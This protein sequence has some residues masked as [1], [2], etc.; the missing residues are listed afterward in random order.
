MTAAWGSFEALIDVDE[1]ETTEQSPCRFDPSASISVKQGNGPFQQV[2]RPVS[3]NYNQPFDILMALN[4][5]LDCEMSFLQSPDRLA[6]AVSRLLSVEILPED[7]SARTLYVV[8]VEIPE[9]ATTNLILA[10][11]AWFVALRVRRDRESVR[12]AGSQ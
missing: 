2:G 4:L 6:A 11:V 8:D 10:A 7:I 3:L 9:P 1:S 12:S 5:S